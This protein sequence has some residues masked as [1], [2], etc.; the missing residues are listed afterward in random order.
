MSEGKC[1][2]CN[3]MLVPGTNIA[4][5]TAGG[6]YASSVGF[7]LQRSVL[8]GEE[9][10]KASICTEASSYS[11]EKRQSLSSFPLAFLCKSVSLD[12]IGFEGNRAIE[13]TR[14]YLSN[15]QRVNYI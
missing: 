6:L 13:R 15:Y 8:D 10:F 2:I 3:G 12:S 7:D 14:T 9:N 5:Q 4:A 11:W 1:F